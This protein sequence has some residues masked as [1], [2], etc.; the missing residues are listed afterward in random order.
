MS[1]LAPDAPAPAA[2][3]PWKSPGTLIVVVSGFLTSATCGW[4]IGRSYFGSDPSGPTR[5]VLAR[6]A[7]PLLH[8]QEETT[9]WEASQN[10]GIT[11]IKKEVEELKK[12]LQ[13]AQSEFVAKKQEFARL[14]S[15]KSTEEQRRKSAI[16][17][18]AK[19]QTIETAFKEA[20]TERTKAEAAQMSSG[21]IQIDYAQWQKEWDALA[22][23]A[24]EKIR[25]AE[26]QLLSI[27]SSQPRWEASRDQLTADQKTEIK[28]AHEASLTTMKA[29]SEA[30]T[31][32]RG[33]LD[34]RMKEQAEQLERAIQE[35]SKK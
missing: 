15:Q 8:A 7:L 22:K 2:L 19:L 28:A 3:S 17:Q 1:S 6:G 23:D 34:Q 13:T 33:R 11:E 18:I 5:A 20:N 25:L 16:D 30:I 24:L 27:K 31:T 21:G 12:R 9:R 10:E 32:A 35:I 4:M 26:E 14:T 29:A